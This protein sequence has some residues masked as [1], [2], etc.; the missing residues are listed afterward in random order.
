MEPPPNSVQDK[1]LL[2]LGSQRSPDWSRVQHIVFLEN[3]SDLLWTTGAVWQV[4]LIRSISR[5]EFFFLIPILTPSFLEHK[6][7]SSKISHSSEKSD[8]PGA[9]VML[10]AGHVDAADLWALMRTRPNTH[11]HH[12]WIHRYGN[13]ATAEAPCTLCRCTKS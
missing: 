11:V 13:T 5:W 3:F 1:S 4:S 8:R 7:K 12:I 2:P 10:A 6:P 9:N